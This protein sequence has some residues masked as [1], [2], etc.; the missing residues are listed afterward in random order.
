[1]MFDANELADMRTAQTAHMM[2]TCKRHVYS[3]TFDSFGDPV[4][5]WTASSTSTACGLDMKA[6]NEVD[7]TTMTTVNY[8]AILRLPIATILDP[9]DRIEITKRF[10][11][12]ITPVIYQIVSPIQRGPSG[13]RVLLRKVEI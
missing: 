8:D 6:G 7:K 3:R 5:A 4:E 11:E 2:D 1:M 9:K 13:I 10:G 12:S